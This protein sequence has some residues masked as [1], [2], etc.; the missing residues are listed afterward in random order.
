MVHLVNTL[1]PTELL[2]FRSEPSSVSPLQLPHI[3]QTVFSYLD[4]VSLSPCLTVNTLWCENALP[5]RWHICHPVADS[6]RSPKR[7]PSE[8]VPSWPM[9]IKYLPYIHTL[10]WCVPELA[11]DREKQL[12]QLV[13]YG[14]TAVRM[15]TLQLSGA[16]DMRLFLKTILPA[17]PGTLKLHLEL[18]AS[19]LYQLVLHHDE[20]GGPVIPLEEI[21]FSSRTQ[22]LIIGQHINLVLKGRPMKS[23]LPLV[24]SVLTPSTVMYG[25]NL[26]D[27]S[28][29]VVTAQRCIDVA[30]HMPNLKTLA[31]T[32][33]G[34][35]Q[36]MVNYS[37]VDP[38]SAG[39]AFAV[40]ISP[41]RNQDSVETKTQQFARDLSLACSKLDNIT[42]KHRRLLEVRAQTPVTPVEQDSS[43]ELLARSIVT[44]LLPR[45]KVLHVD[46]V[47]MH[48]PLLETLA[49]AA[50]ASV[51]TTVET[52]AIS[53]LERI[54]ID[55]PSTLK[56]PP[57]SSKA[58]Q[59]ILENCR[60]LTAFDIRNTFFDL[61]DIPVDSLPSLSIPISLDRPWAC[62]GLKYLDLQLSNRT[63]NYMHAPHTRRHLCQVLIKQISL[64]T[65]MQVLRISG[66]FEFPSALVG[67]G[68]FEPLTSLRMLEVFYVGFDWTKETNQ[69]CIGPTSSSDGTICAEEVVEDLEFTL[70]PRKRQI[71]SPGTL[72]F[73]EKTD[74]EWMVR[75]L[76]AKGTA[77]SSPAP[78]RTSNGQQSN[79]V[80]GIPIL[81][82][83]PQ[84][85]QQQQIQR[86]QGSPYPQHRP[87]R[88]PSSTSS[89]PRNQQSPSSS[90]LQR[91]SADRNNQRQSPTV[92]SSSRNNTPRTRTEATS[93]T[94]TLSPSRA[95]ARSFR[96]AVQ[97]TSRLSTTLGSNPQ[98]ATEIAS[99]Q[100]QSFPTQ[101]TNPPLDDLLTS[102][103]NVEAMLA[104]WESESRDT[105]ERIR[106]L[107]AQEANFLLGNRPANTFL[108]TSSSSTSTA[109]ASSSSTH[110]GPSTT[111]TTSSA[112]ASNISSTY[113]RG[114]PRKKASDETIV[115]SLAFHNSERARARVNLFE[116]VPTEVLCVILGWVVQPI[117]DK[118]VATDD[119]DGPRIGNPLLYWHL[120]PDRTLLRLVCRS[121]N[122]TIVAMARDIHIKLGPDE[123]MDKLLEIEIRRRIRPATMTRTTAL[124]GRIGGTRLPY[125]SLALRNAYSRSQQQRLQQLQRPTLRRSARLSQSASPTTPSSSSPLLSP[126]R[127]AT[128]SQATSAEWDP[129]FSFIHTRQTRDQHERRRLVKQTAVPIQGFYRLQIPDPPTKDVH[130]SSGSSCLSSTG[131]EISK[132]NNP[133]S[134]P[135][136]VSS[137]SVEGDLS[138]S[139]D[140]KEDVTLSSSYSGISPRPGGGSF[141]ASSGEPQYR[142][143]DVQFGTMLDHWL[144]ATT[145]KGL[146]KFSISSSADFGLNGLLS[147][148]RT[149]TTLKISRCPRI[150]GGVLLIGFQ[151]LSNLTSLTVCSELLF[152]DET[153]LIALRTLSQLKHLVYI[154]PCDAVQPAWRDLF[155]YCS[156]CELYHRRVTTKTYSRTLLMP[157]LPDQIQD[158]TFEMD[159]PRF[160]ESRIETFEQNRHG[161]DRRDIRYAI[162]LWKTDDTT[163]TR[164]AAAPWPGF[165]LAQGG[166]RSW[167]PANLTRLDLSK[168]AVTGS[169]FDVPSQLQELVIAY[170]L[171]P[172]EIPA[173]GGDGSYLSV[174]EKQWYPE[175]LSK[176]EILG[177]PYHVPCVLHDESDS[178]IKA[179]MAYTNKMLRTV[180]RHLEHLTTSSFQIP[181]TDAMAAMK[182]R[183][184]DTLRTWKVRLLCPQRPRL[185]AFTILQLYAPFNYVD[186]ESGEDED[187]EEVT[188]LTSGEDTDSDSSME[189][190][191]SYR[192]RGDLSINQRR[193][194]VSTAQALQARRPARPTLGQTRPLGQTTTS[195]GR[196]GGQGGQAAM[197]SATDQ[198]DVTPVMLRHSVRNMKVLE[199]VD[200]YVNYQHFRH[201]RANW[202]GN[203]SLTEPAPI[204]PLPRPNNN[205][206]KEEEGRREG[207]YHADH[208]GSHPRKKLKSILKRP[209][210]SWTTTVI[211]SNGSPF[212]LPV[213]SPVDRKGKGRAQDVEDLKG[214]GRKVE[215]SPQQQHISRD[216]VRAGQESLLQDKGKGVKRDR[217]EGHDHSS[218]LD[219]QEQSSLPT[220]VPG[221]GVGVRSGRQPKMTLR[222]WNNSC[223]GERCLGWGRVH[224][225]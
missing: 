45:L 10:H 96:R 60:T 11:V 66:G 53:S 40:E 97:A 126:T 153:F 95:A 166:I 84:S 108:S 164:S 81:A 136:S 29:V 86:Q 89:S 21:A 28:Q 188:V 43:V 27:L 117:G 113:T 111:L 182:G 167:W 1:P 225:D 207:G 100:Q 32:L 121:W 12:A 61:N 133:W 91:Y 59:R 63:E 141:D 124:Q 139:S 180:P 165:D 26:L 4:Q 106:H 161:L 115:C 16:H 8:L 83:S 39:A 173:T 38:V 201:C 186:D 69:Q 160:Q 223:C 144:R 105:D 157:E 150:N 110:Q 224:L 128:R 70:T 30:L 98:N 199:T 185:S 41:P 131:S 14:W 19:A 93:V 85:Q 67:C 159:E 118:M 36:S 34:I 195:T 109:T 194:R 163:S 212:G 107:H 55:S 215:F 151:H 2:L 158:F 140:P 190:M 33:Q 197:G 156:S 143:N 202:K 58:I 129:P 205:G 206:N 152:T 35:E 15:R 80:I 175:S 77:K 18:S 127:P 114:T 222:Y 79:F 218:C 216:E 203:L 196:Q 214:K 57:V 48:E 52:I 71:A 145:P 42:L 46:M 13:A 171:E 219:S 187:E 138:R 210:A 208:N 75:A 174:E 9:I 47:L 88:I 172:K 22:K 192:P 122:H 3:L 191:A 220:A 82:S 125:L 102:I 54:T 104:S 116:K 134:F 37:G 154:Y 78:S 149:L 179:W 20:K 146:V 178:K 62:I 200:V 103:G 183:V 17:L 135:P 204:I 193:L 142:M 5:F 184:Q 176:L 65:Q 177:V 168:S 217:D 92:A 137:L 132:K 68:D 155:R 76:M 44:R 112:A 25:I 31:L 130:T 56:T 7:K 49:L 123:S 120:D 213:G 148:P 87:S 50:G 74:L 64:L 209:G 101:P 6:S 51:G 24:P 73:F 147:L 99:Q 23:V 90:S 94:S 198:Y 221:I 181:D 72:Q 169:T 119:G 170:P 211:A 162:A 189:Y